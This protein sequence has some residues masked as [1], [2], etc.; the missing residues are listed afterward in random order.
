[1][2]VQAVW[3]DSE[4]AWVAD[5]APGPSKVLCGSLGEYGVEWPCPTAIAALGVETGASDE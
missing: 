5:P 3:P 4:L 1:M 2:A